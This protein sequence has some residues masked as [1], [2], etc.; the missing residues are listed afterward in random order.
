MPAICNHAAHLTLL[1]IAAPRC[2][3]L[4]D[5]VVDTNSCQVFGN[6]PL[7]TVTLYNAALGER[8]TET[9]SRKALY[10]VIFILIWNFPTAPSELDS[11]KDISSAISP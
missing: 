8:K 10:T 7:L 5:A 11:C 2:H 6:E 1:G 4:G 9:L 3:L